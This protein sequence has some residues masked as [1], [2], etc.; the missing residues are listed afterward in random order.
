MTLWSN[1]RF[2]MW[3]YRAEILTLLILINYFY[4]ITAPE[5]FVDQKVS[6]YPYEGVLNL[7]KSSVK[8]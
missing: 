1:S 7:T 6:S 3:I 5:S 4:F 8:A 2:F